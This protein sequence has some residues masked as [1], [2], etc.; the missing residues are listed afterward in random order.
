MWIVSLA[1][2]AGLCLL[3][4]TVVYLLSFHRIG[5]SEVGLVTKRFSRQKLGDD[6]L[7]A[8][9]GEAGYQAEMLMPGLRFRLWPI[10]PAGICTHGNFSTP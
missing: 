6:N 10:C 4:T 3:A 9:N 2:A 8:L 5:P 7:I 1:F